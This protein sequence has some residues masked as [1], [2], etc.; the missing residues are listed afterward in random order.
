MESPTAPSDAVAEL[1]FSPANGCVDGRDEKSD[2]DCLLLPRGA[3]KHCKQ[4]VYVEPGFVAM[5]TKQCVQN[6][7]ELAPDSLP[8]VC[9]ELGPEVAHCV[10]VQFGLY[11]KEQAAVLF[12]VDF[13]A[14]VRCL[15]VKRQSD[16]AAMLVVVHESALHVQGIGK[17]DPL[18]HFAKGIGM[19]HGAVQHEARFFPLG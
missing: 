16:E 11:L 7:E 8:P 1:C 13:D 9:T 17:A 6:A 19:A 12:G 14:F 15:E 5:L 18:G 2:D 4:I 10:V 3:G